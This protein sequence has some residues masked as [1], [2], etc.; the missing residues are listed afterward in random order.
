MEA[1]RPTMDPPEFPTKVNVS[2]RTP[3][4]VDVPANDTEFTPPPN[5]NVEPEPK[6]NRP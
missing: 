2:F 6:E 5:V 1:V 4:Y 3:V